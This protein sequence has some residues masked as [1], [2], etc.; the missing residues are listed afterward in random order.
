MGARDGESGRI[1]DL[2]YFLEPDDAQKGHKHYLQSKFENAIGPCSIISMQDPDLL[3]VD[4]V[5]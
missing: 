3:I 4:A 2:L 1:L 5:A